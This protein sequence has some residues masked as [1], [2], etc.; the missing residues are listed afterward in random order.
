MDIRNITQFAN[1]ISAGQL[2]NLNMSFHQIIMCVNNYASAC[3]CHKGEY[4]R[5]LYDDCTRV[6]TD[7][8]RNVVPKFKND[9]LSKTTERQITFYLDNG[10]IIG[11]ICR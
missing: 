3:N 7:V 8:V 6:Y 2:Q 1:F 11:L 9:F 5:K 4:K 10:T